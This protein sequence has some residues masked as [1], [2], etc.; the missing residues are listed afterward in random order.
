MSQFCFVSFDS[1]GFTLDLGCARRRWYENAAKK[2][3][4]WNPKKAIRSGFA[5]LAYSFIASW[6]KFSRHVAQMIVY[7]PF[8]VFRGSH[9]MVCHEAGIMQY[10]NF[11]NF[12]MFGLLHIRNLLSAPKIEVPI[13][14]LHYNKHKKT[15]NTLFLNHPY[16]YTQVSFVATLKFQKRKKKK[17]LAKQEWFPMLI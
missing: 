13:E 12:C 5:G 9:V 16:P 1:H 7:I 2:K 3:M 10:L 14:F 6:A 17:Y 8:K 11:Q 4:D 15:Q